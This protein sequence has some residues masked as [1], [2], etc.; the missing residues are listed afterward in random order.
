MMWNH[1]WAPSKKSAFEGARW[2]YHG[3]R[4][5]EACAD[6]SR[7]LKEA[8]EKAKQHKWEPKIE[9]LKETIKRWEK[10]AT[11]ADE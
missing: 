2:K 9:R 5:K 4:T 10:K 6:K 8:T 7:G 11:D 1:K 3:T